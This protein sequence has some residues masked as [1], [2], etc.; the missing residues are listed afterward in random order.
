MGRAMSLLHTKHTAPWPAQRPPQEV[1]AARALRIKLPARESFNSPPSLSEVKNSWNCTSTPLY[2]FATCTL[3]TLHITCNRLGLSVSK[4]KIYILNHT[5][6]NASRSTENL[7]PSMDCE[8]SSQQRRYWIAEKISLHSAFCPHL[9]LVFTLND[10]SWRKGCDYLNVIYWNVTSEEV[11]ENDL[12]S[13][14]T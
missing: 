4:D 11:P 9:C 2:A 7:S 3:T 14:W 10:W 12:L 13:W 8:G 1:R 5:L 6:C